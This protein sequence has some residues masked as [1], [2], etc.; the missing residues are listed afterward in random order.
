MEV[1]FT[2]PYGSLRFLITDILQGS[3]ATRLRCGGYV[4]TVYHKFTP[5]PVGERVLLVVRVIATESKV[6]ESAYT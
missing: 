2:Q 4:I 1:R 3:V 6:S 5:E